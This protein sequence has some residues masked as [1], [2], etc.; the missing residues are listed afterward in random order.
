MYDIIVIGAGPAGISAAVYA[1]SRGCRTLVLEQKEVGG[2][3]GT[4][5]SVTHYSGIIQ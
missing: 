3:I 4:V 2:I 1:V 5:S